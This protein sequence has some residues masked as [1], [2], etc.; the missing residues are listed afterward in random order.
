MVLLPENSYPTSQHLA[1][2]HRTLSGTPSLLCLC[3]PYCTHIVLPLPASLCPSQFHFKCHGIHVASL[4]SLEG[5]RKPEH[6][7]SFSVHSLLHCNWFSLDL[8]HLTYAT[9]MT[10]V[11]LLFQQHQPMVTIQKDY[12]LELSQ[13]GQT[14]YRPPHRPHD[15]FLTLLPVS[16]HPPRWILRPVPSCPSCNG[17]RLVKTL[18]QNELWHF[19]ASHPFPRQLHPAVWH[20]YCSPGLGGLPHPQSSSYSGPSVPVTCH[21]LSWHKGSSKWFLLPFSPSL[22]LLQPLLRH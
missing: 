13:S 19:P 17:S 20:S 6:I 11:S 9:S 16:M 15:S 1:Y 12:S 8:L 18:R 3:L 14:L 21:L 7:T 5:I 4:P 2:L 10:Y 22:P